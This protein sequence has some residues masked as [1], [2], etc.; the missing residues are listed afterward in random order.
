MDI[1]YNIV[2]NALGTHGYVRWGRPSVD[3]Q[4]CLLCS[5]GYSI[6]KH[7][8]WEELWSELEKAGFDTKSFRECLAS[9]EER[10][11]ADLADPCGVN[12]ESNPY[13][14]VRFIMSLRRI[15]QKKV[16]TG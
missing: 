15:P 9:S 12:Y 5:F 13:A 11:L 4:S 14:T 8:F 2:N 7:P 1:V 16:S 3:N 6:R 10:W